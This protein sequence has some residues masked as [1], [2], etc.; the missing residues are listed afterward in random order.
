MK[1]IIVSTTFILLALTPFLFGNQIW[2]QDFEFQNKDTDEDFI[3]GDFL[4]FQNAKVFEDAIL[5]MEEEDVSI[6]NYFSEADEIDDWKDLGFLTLIAQRPISEASRILSPQ[7]HFQDFGKLEMKQSVNNGL[8]ELYDGNGKLAW[9][10]KISGQEF[11]LQRNHLTSGIY[12]YKISDDGQAI[13]SG[14]ILMN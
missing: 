4:E 2:N 13:N 8:I 9:Q 12:F 6:N 5:L 10:Q 14:K 11:E 1:K 3:K 7:N